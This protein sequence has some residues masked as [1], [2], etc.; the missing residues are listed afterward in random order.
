M[1]MHVYLLC[2]YS[3]VHTYVSV[4]TEELCQKFVL[5]ASN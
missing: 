4:Y 5:F 3:T 2:M 1:C